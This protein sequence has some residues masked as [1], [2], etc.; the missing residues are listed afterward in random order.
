MMTPARAVLVHENAEMLR[1]WPV[2]VGVAV[3]IGAA[4]WAGSFVQ[5]FLFRVDAQ[6]SLTLAVTAVA[7]VTACA[8]AAWVP[9]RRAARI[10]P[11][12]VLKSL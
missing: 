8:V 1:V 7:L 11:A 3:G 10:D 4:F 5:S 6:D 9:A 12:N 2:L